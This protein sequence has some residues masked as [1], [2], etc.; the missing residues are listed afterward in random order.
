MF[1]HGALECLIIWLHS[2]LACDLLG[3][4]GMPSL[5]EDG[6]IVI[7]GIFPVSN[8]QNILHASFEEKPGDITCHG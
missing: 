3:D 6:D 7:G 2:C 8:K 5:A 1:G 4:F